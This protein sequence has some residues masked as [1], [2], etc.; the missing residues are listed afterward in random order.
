M[1]EGKNNKNHK[2]LILEGARQVGKTWLN[3]C[4][5]VYQIHKITKPDLPIGAYEDLY[6]FEPF[7][8]DLGLLGVLV[9]LDARTILDRYEIFTEFKDAIAEQYVLQQFKPIEAVN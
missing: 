8:L 4:G 5:L 9:N 7:V 6:S 3:D 2:P 1:I